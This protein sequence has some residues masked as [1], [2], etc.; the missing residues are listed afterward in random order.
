ML[1]DDGWLGWVGLEMEVVRR[2]VGELKLGA[3]G[4]EVKQHHASVTRE[5]LISGTWLGRVH[6]LWF[7][8]MAFAWF[9][10]SS[11]LANTGVRGW[12]ARLML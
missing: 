2:W 7:H 8:A 9:L 3:D 1:L 6:A 10:L 4:H 5:L 12:G 11:E